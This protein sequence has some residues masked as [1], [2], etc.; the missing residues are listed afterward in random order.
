M[1][2]KLLV[3]VMLILSSLPFNSPEVESA[4]LVE[5]KQQEPKLEM[6]DLEKVTRVQDAQ[7]LKGTDKKKLKPG[8]EVIEERTE[9]TKT[10]Y[11]GDNTFTR[12]VYF[13]P[14]HAK[15]DGQEEFEEISAVLVDDT[16]NGN[17]VETENAI[18]NSS[19]LKGMDN[20]KYA[21]FEKDGHTI[22]YSFLE[23]SGEGLESIHARDVDA[24]FEK[25]KITHEQV[26]PDVDLRNL[27][28]GE[29]IK[30]DLI[31]H[32]YQGYHEF[33]FFLETDLKAQE[34]NEGTILFKDEKGQPVFY[35]PK[36]YMED[37]N[38]N[39]N[40]GESERSENVHYEIKKTN[41][42]YLL[43]VKADQRWLSDSN[44]KYPVFIDPSTSLGIE[45]DTFIMSA[46]PNANFS[47]STYKWDENQGEY[48][49]KVGNYDNTTGETYAF[50]KQNLDGLTSSNGYMVTDAKLNVFVTHAYYY[51]SP[52]GLWIDAVNNAWSPEIITWNNK[53][54]S[55]PITSVNV[56]RDQT[57]SFNVTNIVKEWVKG[58]KPTMDSSF[59]RMVTGIHIGKE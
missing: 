52:N 49:L 51:N 38:Y 22:S 3:I 28:F 15:K 56:G 42:G 30:E 16:M 19:F 58:K 50:L 54:T 11:N 25:N 1:G 36:P 4:S 45:Q 41:G 33:T 37:S 31:L 21:T 14:V 2:L 7:P 17:Q 18:L 55:T 6:I 40:K 35:V 20:G 24:K 53:P 46:W 57:A 29:N 47:S 32:S 44:R 39:D 27:T 43:T 48:V 5:T 59:I 34:Q 10:F 23:A 26:F 9:K 13:E 12:K 8:E